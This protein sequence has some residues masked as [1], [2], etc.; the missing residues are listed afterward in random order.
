VVRG[1]LAALAAIYLDV[2]VNYDSLQRKCRGKCSVSGVAD[3]HCFPMYSAGYGRQNHALCIVFPALLLN[4]PFGIIYIYTCFAP[5][6]PITPRRRQ[7]EQP[8][9]ERS[10]VDLYIGLPGTLKRVQLTGRL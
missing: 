7:P 10:S 9:L 6:M 2:G 4:S 1:P 5:V 3:M 8:V